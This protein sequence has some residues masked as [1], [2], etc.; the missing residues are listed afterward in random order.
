MKRKVGVKYLRDA[1]GRYAGSVG[2]G[3]KLVREVKTAKSIESERKKILGELGTE[4]RRRLAKVLAQKSP[5][6]DELKSGKQFNTTLKK[7]QKQ[8]KVKAKEDEVKIKELKKN[9]KLM[10]AAKRIGT[11]KEKPGDGALV[12]ETGFPARKLLEEKKKFNN[13]TEK[14]IKAD[15][16]SLQISDNGVTLW[17]GTEHAKPRGGFKIKKDKSQEYSVITDDGKLVLNNIKTV[18]EYQGERIRGVPSVNQYLRQIDNKALVSNLHT[19]VGYTESWDKKG[20]PAP[21]PYW[22]SNRF[23]SV[24]D[25]YK[26]DRGY[27][28]MELHHVGQWV[29]HDMGQLQA[30]VNSGKI[31]LDRAKE[32]MKENLREAP[33]HSKGYEIAASEKRE[34]IILAAGTHNATAGKKLYRE[35]HPY[36]YHPETGELTEFGIADKDKGSPFGVTE[37]RQYHNGIR[38]GF[39]SEF[40]RREAYVLA[41]EVN[42]RL[43]NGEMTQDEVKQLWAERAKTK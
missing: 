16:N 8:Q 37:G 38:N 22:D 29:K 32:L 24:P 27:G 12:A 42:R 20:V 26:P 15:P 41:G 28:N 4:Q 13:N 36:G 11:D 39:W 2:S 21:A 18:A 6:K 1:N 31:T 14:R 19:Q 25:K 34:Y 30:D 17:K 43:R 23:G 5:S 35:N 40:S 10:N 9:R 3:R 33:W 7:A